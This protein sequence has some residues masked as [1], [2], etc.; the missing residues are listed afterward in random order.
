MTVWKHQGQSIFY[1]KKLNPGSVFQSHIIM[2]PWFN[3]LQGGGGCSLYCSEKVNL[4]SIVRG[5]KISCYYYNTCICMTI[6]NIA[7]ISYLPPC[8]YF[9]SPTLLS[10]TMTISLD[11]KSA[12]NLSHDLLNPL[13]LKFWHILCVLY[14]EI[15]PYIRMVQHYLLVHALMNYYHTLEKPECCQINLCNSNNCLTTP[16]FNL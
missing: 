11:I 15:K 10:P 2:N 1:C 13:A 9:R 14:D 3:I 12:K 7:F 5:I 6:S 4:G 8:L 16:P